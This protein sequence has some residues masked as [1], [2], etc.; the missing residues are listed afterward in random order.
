MRLHII[1]R[2]DRRLQRPHNRH[3]SH[4]LMLA[5][6]P[7]HLQHRN[8]IRLAPWLLQYAPRMRDYYGVGGD[9][10]GRLAFRTVNLRLVD[11]AGFGG[12]GFEDV[13]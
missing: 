4:N 12:R 13:V 6:I 8:M 1:P 9:N 10:E 3:R 2:R 11:V 7:Q 5:L